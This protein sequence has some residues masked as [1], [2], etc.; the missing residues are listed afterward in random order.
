MDGTYNNRSASNVPK[1]KIIPEIG[2]NGTNIH[3]KDSNNSVR[4]SK[5][6]ASVVVVVVG[7]FLFDVG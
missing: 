6:V 2:M 3:I 7:E 5:G 4:N 1:V